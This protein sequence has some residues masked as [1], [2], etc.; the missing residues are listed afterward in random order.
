V[1]GRLLVVA[2]PIGNLGDL[3]PRAAE[4]LRDADLV[5]CEDTR[6]TATLL[7]AAG[8]GAPMLPAYEHNEAARAADLVRRMRDGARVVLVSD[9]GMP[10]ISD[11]GHRIVRAAVEAGVP[12]SVIP[13]PGAVESALVASGISAEAGYVF[14]GF[15]PRKASERARA[16]EALQGEARPAVLFESPKRL[17]ALLADLAALEPGR[18]VAVCREMTKIHE[19]VVRGTAAEV[20]ARFPVPPRGEITVVVGPGPPREAAVASELASAMARLLDAGL[21]PGQAASAAAALGLARRN[22]AY[23]AALAAAESR[24]SR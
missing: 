4:A 6:R 21:T 8:S 12:V 2:T 24:R 22:A 23:E 15:L 13:G 9:A 11:P 18:A 16:L 5:A 19:E 20:A 17:P 10:C 7:R 1:T 14:L 3:S